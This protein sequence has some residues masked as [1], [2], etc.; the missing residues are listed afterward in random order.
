MTQSHN[1]RVLGLPVIFLLIISMIAFFGMSTPVK[2]ANFT[3]KY[4]TIAPKGTIW[5]RYMRKAKR[6]IEKKSNKRIKFRIYDGGKA[7]SEKTMLRKLKIGNLDMAAFTGIGLG[8][9]LPKTRVLELPFFFGSTRQVDKVVNKLYPEFEKD[10]AKKGFVLAGWG[11]T[12]WVYVMS[13]TPIRSYADMKGLKVWAPVGDKL[14]KA[15]FEEYGLV[16]V[17]LSFEAVLPQLQTGGLDAVYAP[18]AGAIGLQWFREVKY[19]SNI[20]LANATG[21]TLIRKKSYDKMPADLKKILLDTSKKYARQ[22]VIATRRENSK[23]FRVLQKRG[24]KLVKVNKKDL[25]DLKRKA[26]K[27]QRK[28]VARGLFSNALL[29]R[30]K[31]FRK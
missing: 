19:I 6:E 16:P 9:I 28:L 27:I 22:L 4:A 30:A 2:A 31:K 8:T 7:G 17:Y 24:L 23:A 20:R 21:A 11:E 14:V 29:S 15:M 13:K 12:G 18:P 10:F 26:L 25:N 3:I 1:F 5:S